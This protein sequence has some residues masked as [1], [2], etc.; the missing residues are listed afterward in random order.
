VRSKSSRDLDPLEEEALASNSSSHRLEQPPPRTASREAHRPSRE[1]PW[2]VDSSRISVGS[3]VRKSS[4]GHSPRDLAHLDSTSRLP[5]RGRSLSPPRTF[6]VSVSR[7]RERVAHFLAHRSHS[8]ERDPPPDPLE[9]GYPALGEGPIRAPDSS[10]WWWTLGSPCPL[11]DIGWR[12][13]PQRAHHLLLASGSTGKR[14]QSRQSQLFTTKRGRSI[15]Q[16][17]RTR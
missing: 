16:R 3:P 11:R 12:T 1:A 8:G 15:S 17:T 4:K 14:H 13:L 9:E 10:Q 6:P 7:P 2:R 5:S